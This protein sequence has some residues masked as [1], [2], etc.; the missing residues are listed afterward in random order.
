[1]VSDRFQV[2]PTWTDSS[3]PLAA[4]LTTTPGGVDRSEPRL[5]L[6][7]ALQGDVGLFPED[8][9]VLQRV[10]HRVSSSVVTRSCPVARGTNHRDRPPRHRPAD[11]AER[12]AYS[13]LMTR[14]M[15]SSRSPK[16]RNADFIA[17][18]VNQRRSSSV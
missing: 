9:Q 6:L 7:G 10:W 18:I 2:K 8:V 14:S 4:T 11:Y 17:L 5:H 3:R 13:G 15:I 12:A 16:G 1:M